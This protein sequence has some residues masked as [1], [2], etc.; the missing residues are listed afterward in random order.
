METWINK[1]YFSD[2]NVKVNAI[3]NEEM[4]KKDES[5][6]SLR[7]TINS[8]MC[9][10]K[11]ST[12]ARAKMGTANQQLKQE[13]QILMDLQKETEEINEKRNNLFTENFE[14]M[15]KSYNAKILECV[16]C[17]FIIYI[18]KACPT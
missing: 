9:Q 6:S 3:S 7:D 4:R 11:A 14:K 18:C 2:K 17:L 1:L 16:R 13:H 12:D 5:L 15:K 8:L 10:L